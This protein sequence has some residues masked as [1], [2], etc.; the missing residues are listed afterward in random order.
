MGEVLMWSGI[1]LATMLLAY[2]LK[3]RGIFRAEDRKFI[4]D[5][6]FY[7]TLPAMLIGSFAETAVTL[8]FMVAF[9]AGLAWNALVLPLTLAV[10][11][12]KAPDMQALYIINCAGINL[13]NIAIPFLGN[14]YPAGVPYLCMM[15]T[16]DC[17]FSLGTTYAIASGRMGQKR[18]S[19]AAQFAGILKSLLH[20]V[21]FITY[22]TMTI[23]SLLQVEL[24]YVVLEAAGF[25]GRGNGFLA[26]FLV[27]L[28][29]ELNLDR[30]SI[31]EIV[32]IFAV[33]Y[34]CGAILA[35]AIWFLLPTAPLVMRQVLVLA[36]FS[37][38]TNAALIYSTR[39][40]V[41]TDIAGILTP[42][43]TI[44]MIPVMTLVMLLMG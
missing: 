41:R 17:F 8:W 12:K 24:P 35:L 28:S 10:V 7:V 19:L 22:V 9:A 21:P 29:L 3:R 33:R 2:A 4:A 18:D 32:T 40:G 37:P 44:L 1:Y 25:V 11:R 23:L 34:S 31:R 6:I 5:L 43:S 13:G 30:D 39:L 20:S 38:A 14:F 27:G 16:G 26:M 36:C 15:D 42:I